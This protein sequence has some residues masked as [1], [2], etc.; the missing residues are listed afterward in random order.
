MTPDE[1][2]ME[3]FLEMKYVERPATN[4]HFLQFDNY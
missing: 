4:N 2:Q 3:L 1:M